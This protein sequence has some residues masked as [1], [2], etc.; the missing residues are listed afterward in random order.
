[1]QAEERAMRM[2][3]AAE[4]SQTEMRS[5]LRLEQIAIK[6]SFDTGLLTS[7]ELKELCSLVL[8]HLTWMPRRATEP[9]PGAREP[10]RRSVAAGPAPP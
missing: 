4:A 10:S 2:L 6:G 8:R 7:V 5:I 3:Q 9:R 1:M